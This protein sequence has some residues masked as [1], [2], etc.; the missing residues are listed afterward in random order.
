MYPSQKTPSPS[1]CQNPRP[2]QPPGEPTSQW[3]RPT[4]QS[5]Q[6]LPLQ[7]FSRC[8]PPPQTPL[9]S[10]VVMDLATIKALCSQGLGLS[11]IFGYTS[12]N[13]VWTPA[14]TTAIPFAE[15]QPTQLPQLAYRKARSKSLAGGLQTATNFTQGPTTSAV[16]NSHEKSTEISARPLGNPPS[17]ANLGRIF[18]GEPTKPLAWGAESVRFAYAAV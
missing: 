9:Y 16:S 1:S 18:V 7:S 17:A 12:R 15:E 11:R 4:T 10:P 8:T 14:D 6:E 13:A 3:L 2:T 5:A